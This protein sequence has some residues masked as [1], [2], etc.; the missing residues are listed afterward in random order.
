[1][2]DFNEI[3]ILV[4]RALDEDVGRGDMT[5]EATI[6][7]EI[8]AKGN[9]LAKQPGILAGLE[10][11]RLAF[12]LVDE[13]VALSAISHDGDHIMPGH[14]FATISGPGRALLTAER[15]AL[16]FLQRMSGIATL[17]GKMVNAVQGTR[18]VILDTRKTSPGIRA[19]DKWAVRLG[20]GQNH[21][22]GLYD[23]V[24]IKDNHITIIG[25]LTEA[26]RRVQAANIE[27]RPIEVEVKN[28]QEVREAL[29]LR[30]D[31]ILLDNMSLDELYEAVRI[32]HGQT[33]L[34][35]SGNVTLENIAAIA[36]T[37]VDF[38]SVGALTHS[39]PALDMSLKLYTMTS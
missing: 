13:R 20:G 14:I 26:V 31:R 4:R 12:T 21:R 37:G 2:M 24:L 35:A 3:L 38:I 15:V 29:S 16:N 19:L 7:P 39:A 30:V 17:T 23:G 10:V 18:A 8:T 11:A 22:N 32:S 25:G 5:T 27:K 34:E 1:M 9:F 6:P 33:S 28:L 36:A